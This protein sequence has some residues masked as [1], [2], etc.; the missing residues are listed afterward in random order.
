MLVGNSKF[1]LWPKVEEGSIFR[2]QEYETYFDDLKIEPDK[3]IG[4]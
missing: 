3:E 4:A 2:T 1:G